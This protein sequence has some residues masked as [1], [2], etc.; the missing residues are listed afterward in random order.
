MQFFQSNYN[1][2]VAGDTTIGGRKENQDNMGV[3]DT[4]LGCLV[5]V[6]D[7][8]GG[9]PGGRTASAI[10][11]DAISRTVLNANPQSPRE[12]VLRQAIAN[13]QYMLEQKVHEVPQLNGMGSTAVAVLINSDSAV[14]AHVGDSRCYRIKT[15][16]MMFRTID[17]SLVS[18]LVQHKTLSEEEA[19]TSPQSNVI[20]RGLGSMSNHI[21]DISIVPFTKGDRFI[22]CS[23]GVWGIMPHEALL[24]RFASKQS[25]ESIVETLQTEVDKIGFASGGGHDNH[26]LIIFETLTDSKLKDKMTKQTIA[27]IATLSVLLLI[28]MAV[29]VFGRQNP[30]ESNNHEAELKDAIQQIEKLKAIEN[31]YNE[32]KNSD[33]GTTYAKIIELSSTNDSLVKLIVEQNQKIT[34]L[35][36]EIDSLKQRIGTN[37]PAVN[38]SGNVKQ[39]GKV[40]A[41]NSN[42]DVKSFAPVDLVERILSELD[43][44]KDYKEKTMDKTVSG[45]QQI[46][47]R[48]NGYLT[49]L[50]N[51]TSN[52]YSASIRP[53][54]NILKDANNKI[55]KVDMPKDGYYNSTQAAKN[56]IDKLK[57][58]IK[59]N[60]QKKL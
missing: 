24:N 30:A 41:N 37:K 25:L 58:N 40:G 43:K 17:H 10:A 42:V 28:S 19:R 38:T 2:L 15:N 35:T 48:I 55:Y 29:N 44:L 50:N 1:I 45:K 34:R 56:E 53:I 36:H 12:D 54:F 20:T 49:E 11:V 26:T 33:N 7:G 51:S 57:N 47:K 23:D 6:C 59:D 21:P 31:R 27:I 4:A 60:I 18:E 8:M 52:K 14:V 5:V 16:K 3:I 22:L 39:N 13:A 46:G 9:G 32:L